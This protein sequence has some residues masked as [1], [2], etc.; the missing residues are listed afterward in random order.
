MRLTR[1]GFHGAVFYGLMVGAFY[2]SPYSNLFFLLLGFLTLLWLTGVVA[3]VRNVRGVEAA[4]ATLDPVPAKTDVCLPAQVSAP[5]RARFQ[6]DLRLRLEGGHLLEGRV[7][8][9]DGTALV[10]LRA[11][12]LPRG[13]HR[14]ERA[15]LVSSHPFGLVRMTRGIDAPRELVVYP[16]PAGLMEG[17]S[18]NET[19]DE[20][21]GRNDPGGGDL[22]PSG[23]RDHREHEGVRGVHWRASARRGQLVVQEWEGG[24]GEGLEVSL[25]RRC[26][27]EELEEAL[28]T[29]S[30]M[31]ELARVDKESLRLHSQDLSAT[32]GDG[33]RPWI[34]ALRFLASADFL[35]PS[36]PGPAATSPSVA[37]LPR[38]TAVHGGRDD[39]R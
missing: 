35:P 15:E 11:S 8:C 25:D 26:S 39:V 12:G 6:V 13:V 38:R 34:D 33:H 32:F 37:R 17:R 2:A 3:A 9:L 14:V 19:L 21:L 23:L 1:F 30:A 7:D 31:V 22:Q 4:V 16:A 5:G 36:A 10:E 18:A 27:D 29:L 20:L 28:A 24:S